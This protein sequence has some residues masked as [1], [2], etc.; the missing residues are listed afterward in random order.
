MRPYSCRDDYEGWLG[1][2]LGGGRFW[3]VNRRLTSLTNSRCWLHHLQTPS[4]MGPSGVRISQWWAP[5]EHRALTAE[6]MMASSPM[7]TIGHAH[8]LR[9]LRLESH[10]GAAPPRP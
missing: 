4:L 8:H 6:E 1:D 5:A 7:S 3:L 10:E 9:D 2:D